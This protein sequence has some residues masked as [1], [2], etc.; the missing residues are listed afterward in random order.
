MDALVKIMPDNKYKT[1]V[2][3]LF[4]DRIY[5][6]MYD[7]KTI[8]VDKFSNLRIFYADNFQIGTNIAIE[9]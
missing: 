9:I 3:G 1:R 5:S 4:C 2:K 6:F 7:I 8:K